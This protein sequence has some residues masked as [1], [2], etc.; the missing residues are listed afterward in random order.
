MVPRS[1]VIGIAKYAITVLGMNE[2]VMI[3]LTI[4]FLTKIMI[5]IQIILFLGKVVL[6]IIA[7]RL[8]VLEDA[9]VNTA[10]ATAIIECNG[11]LVGLAIDELATAII[12]IVLLSDALAIDVIV[13]AAVDATV[14]DIVVLVKLFL[15]PS[16]AAVLTE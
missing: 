11:H 10:P 14:L 13:I 8:F 5:T 1:V 9:R 2:V 12:T 7:L 4:H 16:H 3:V 6:P 15:E